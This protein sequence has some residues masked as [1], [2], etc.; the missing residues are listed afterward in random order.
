MILAW[1]CSASTSSER[2]KQAMQG[3]VACNASAC[4]FLACV[5]KAGSR[6]AG[7]A[8]VGF[9]SVG[10]CPREAAQVSSVRRHAAS[11]ERPTP[12]AK[13]SLAHALEELESGP[14]PLAG[15]WNSSPSGI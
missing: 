8:Q 7:C 4:I 3:T 2:A 15:W 11:A 5:R 13:E 14:V 9:R 1:T 12:C 10:A 6:F